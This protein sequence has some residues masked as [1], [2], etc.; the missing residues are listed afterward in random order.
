MEGRFSAVQ[1]GASATLAL[2]EPSYS[3]RECLPYYGRHK[4]GNVSADLGE[5]G[6]LPVVFDGKY[7]H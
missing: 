2:T 3:A 5:L 7:R 1:I 6:R 4:N